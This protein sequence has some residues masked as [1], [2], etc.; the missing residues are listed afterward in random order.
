MNLTP[1]RII[2]SAGPLSRRRFLKRSSVVAVGMPLA[3]KLPF[4]ATSRAALADPIRVGLIGCGARGVGAARDAL[5]AAQGVSVVALADVFS[6][7]V[8]RARE[9]LARVGQVIAGDH[10]FSGLEAYER[11]LALPE[12]NYVIHAT[13]PGFRPGHF[14]AIV[15]AGK[16]CFLEMPVAVD[17]P[18]VLSVIGSGELARQKKLSVVVGTQRRHQHNY[19]ETVKRLQNGAIGTI[20]AAR[21]RGNVQGEASLNKPAGMTDMEWQ[22]RHW[23]YYTW[24]SGDPYVTQHVHSLD[25]VNWVLRAHPVKASGMGGRQVRTMGHVYDHFA[26]EYQYADGALLFSYTRQINGCEEDVSESVVGTRGT[27]DCF[28]RIEA[29]QGRSWKFR[30]QTTIQGALQGDGGT[31]NGY[32]QEHADLIRAIRAG[33]PVNEANQG[34][35]STLTAIMGREAAYSGL[36]VGWDKILE[37]KLDLTPPRIEM[38]DVPVPPVPM[39]GNYTFR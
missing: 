38:G 1:R 9:A 6:D 37:A 20:V 4:V 3:I 31:N 11:L 34:A 26:V 25:V 39:P 21:A 15:G 35:E 16:H 22:L 5:K 13:P 10:C 36:P 33:E 27:S 32:L 18:G 29:S 30:R 7:R 2:A 8:E 24:L 14:R 19:Q 12:V 17:P 28:Q 23:P